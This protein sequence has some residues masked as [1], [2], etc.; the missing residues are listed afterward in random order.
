MQCHDGGESD[1]RAGVGGGRRKGAA[2]SVLTMTTLSPSLLP[3]MLAWINGGYCTIPELPSLLLPYMRGSVTLK[4]NTHLGCHHL[5]GTLTSLV[6][7]SLVCL[8]LIAVFVLSDDPYGSS[9]GTG[10]AWKR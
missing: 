3:L 7:A 8:I 10:T 6:L 1:G 5:S 4:R 2:V 9:G